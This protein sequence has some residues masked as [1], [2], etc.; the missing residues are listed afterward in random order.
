MTEPQKDP[1][2]KELRFQLTVTRAMLGTLE[3]DQVLY[4]ILTGI[5]HGEGLGFNRAFLFLAD[6]AGRELRAREAAGPADKAEAHRIWEEMEQQELDLEQILEQF[7][8]AAEDP[9]ARRLAHRM[10]GFVVPLSATAPPL[11]ENE[12][13]VPIQALIARCAQE[14]EPVY[15][16]RITAVY[17]PLDDSAG[18][19][20]E[21]KHLAVVPLLLRDSVLGVILADNVYNEAEVLPEQMR[22]LT[23]LGNLA[24]IAIEKARLHQRL[25]E[26][27][28][29]DGLTGVFNRRH[30]EMRLEQEVARARRTGRSLSLLLFDIDHFKRANDDHGHEVGDHVLR[31]LAR[32]LRERV[33]AEDLVARYGGEE[34]VV[35]LTGGATADESHRVAEKLRS[36]VAERSLGGRPA[37]EITLSGGV[38][39]LGPDLLEGPKLFRLADQALYR[40]KQQGRNQVVLAED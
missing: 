15:S 40:A 19:P 31:D 29:L 37:G 14:R 13:Q 25:R 3:L 32:E 35:L 4:I 2:L 30:Y 17:P 36:S 8:A 34:F 38:A 24:A 22:G 6:E 1:L 12:Q 7:A 11:D 18:E 26:M 27:A 5:T 10:A 23:T 9:K 16:N 39:H 21:F 20:V 33:R 28:A